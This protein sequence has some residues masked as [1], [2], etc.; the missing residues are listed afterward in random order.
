MDGD[1]VHNG[2]NLGFYWDTLGHMGTQ[3][4]I[5][6]GLFGMQGGNLGAQGDTLVDKTML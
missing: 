6:K 2:D 1:L 3:L 4:W 5:G